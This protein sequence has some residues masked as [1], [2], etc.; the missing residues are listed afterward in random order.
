[1]ARRTRRRTNTRRRRT[2]PT[3]TSGVQNQFKLRRP[4]RSTVKA[5]AP[6]AETKKYR[7]YVGPQNNLVA[8]G[9]REFY[10]NNNT[11]ACTFLNVHSFIAMKKSF[12]AGEFPW[13]VEGR[14]IFSKFVQMKL[15][16][17]Y[18]QARYGPTSGVRPLEVIYG[19]VEPLNLTDQTTPKEDNVTIAEIGNHI[20]GQVGPDFDEENDPLRF[21]DRR[22]R[23][24]NI[25]GR[26][27]VRPNRRS[28]I[29]GPIANAD[30]GTALS[31][32]G[33]IPPMV[34]SCTFKMNKKVRMH[35]S[36][37]VASGPSSD[38]ILYPRSAYL[39]FVA[40][41]NPDYESYADNVD[42]GKE[43]EEIHQIRVRFNDCHWFHDF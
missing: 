32:N 10:V 13:G 8:Q 36:T 31:T 37:Q 39:P 11:S 16:I 24:Y 29:T 40:I 35:P 42:I 18:P 41:V 28:I 34:R 21:H 3:K 9:I 26:F 25:V 6:I 12:V 15:E 7:W 23:A 1:M 17:Q 30:S 33:D 43:T 38:P 14:D 4:R 27:K 20:A 19:F 22:R 5:I 2:R